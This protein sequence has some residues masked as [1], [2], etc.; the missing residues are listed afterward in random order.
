MDVTPTPKMFRAM[1]VM[2]DAFC[3]EEPLAVEKSTTAETRRQIRRTM[4]DSLHRLVHLAMRE[5]AA[6]AMNGGRRVEGGIMVPL[7]EDIASGFHGHG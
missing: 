2:T 6:R 3:G 1:S 4:M 7:P 5:G